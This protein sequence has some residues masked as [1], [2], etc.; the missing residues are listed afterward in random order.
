MVMFKTTCFDLWKSEEN[1]PKI[2]TL[3]KDLDEHLEGGIASQIVTE[4]CG[5]PG[6]GKTQMW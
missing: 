1:V 2:P 3:C 5:G 6:S 4:F